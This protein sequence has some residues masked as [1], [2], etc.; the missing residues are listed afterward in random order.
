ME[1]PHRALIFLYSFC[2]QSDDSLHHTN[3]DCLTPSVDAECE[4]TYGS[5]QS[6]EIFTIYD[7]QV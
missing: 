6:N 3:L 7:I 2:T 4:I 1:K 5:S